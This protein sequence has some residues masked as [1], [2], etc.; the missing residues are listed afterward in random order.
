MYEDLVP[1]VVPGFLSSRLEIG[2]VTL[3]LRSLSAN[4]T[5]LLRKVAREGGPDWAFHLAAAS[6]WMIDGLSL[7][8]NYPYSQKIAFDLLKRT[9]KSVVRAVFAQAVSFFHR[10]RK[11]NVV[12]EAFLYEEES[13]R[14]W[15][16]TNNGSHPIWI[17]SGMPGMDRIGLNPFQ[18][19][20]VQWNRSEDDRLD[21][22][23]S[24]SLTKVLVSVQS[25]K[26]AKKLDA[27]DRT[28]AEGEKS[29][30]AEVMNR[31]YWTF[32]G[33]LGEDG[34]EKV[35][36][37]LM[38]LQPRTPAELSEEMRRWVAG[39]KDI[40]DLV[41]EDYK[42]RIKAE[43]EAKE[44]E[45]ELAIQQA[46]ERNLLEESTLGA[47]K[48]RLVGYTADQ[49]AKLRPGPVKPGAKFV[50]E[51][52]PTS[53]NFNRYLRDNPS[54]GS[55]DVEGGRVIVKNPSMVPQEEEVESPPTLNEQIARRKPT[56]NG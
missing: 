25:S 23:Y 33:V 32:K 49:L 11:A 51:A 43:Y 5:N 55:L 29:R 37:L 1:L 18:A 56:L 21:D 7:L 31:A 30:R 54:P 38:V 20:W 53:R 4:D 14:L 3:G 44:R 15:K 40:H 27:K 24:W 13:R 9:H 42:N 50:I 52:N 12:F 35:H 17:L 41:V 2:G 8:E 36:P 10:M 47:P 39:E 28:R 19:S 45:T 48:P 6:I 34:K 46:R 26:S 22:D 16:S